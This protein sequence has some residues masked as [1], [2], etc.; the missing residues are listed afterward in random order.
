MNR[1]VWGSSS[2]IDCCETFFVSHMKKNSSKCNEIVKRVRSRCNW[3]EKFVT[4]KTRRYKSGGPN[5]TWHEDVS[6][7]LRPYGLPIHGTSDWFSRK[8][9][10]LKV[11]KSSNNLINLACFFVEAVKRN[12]GFVQTSQNGRTYWT[13]H[14]GGYTMCAGRKHCVQR[15]NIDL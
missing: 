11:C 3:R 2:R 8:I 10:R 5:N 12:L 1:E 9:L 7:K 15:T 4:T 13:L 6:G 14:N